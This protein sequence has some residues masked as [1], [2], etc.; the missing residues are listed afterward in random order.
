MKA[1]AFFVSGPPC[2]ACGATT[3]SQRP[4]STG[5]KV[6]EE[7]SWR[8]SMSDP[9]GRSGVGSLSATDRLAVALLRRLPSA[10]S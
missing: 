8:S 9:S 3:I 1:I 6:C 2:A 7:N 5:M 10:S 4:T